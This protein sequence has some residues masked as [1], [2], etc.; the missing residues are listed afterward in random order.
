MNNWTLV[1]NALMNVVTPR[2]FVMV[3]MP[4]TGLAVI[5]AG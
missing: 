4:I 1:A 5:I 2:M 3:Y